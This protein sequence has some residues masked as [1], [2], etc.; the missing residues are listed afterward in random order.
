[1]Q[2]TNDSLLGESPVFDTFVNH[3][4]FPAEALSFL[5]SFNLYT[6]SE[7]SKSKNALLICK[8]RA[9]VECENRLNHV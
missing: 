9:V 8:Y 3:V 5:H 2:D 1:M 4:L 7:A 6:G